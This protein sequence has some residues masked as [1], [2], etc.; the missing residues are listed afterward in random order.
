MPSIQQMVP[1]PRSVNSTKNFLAICLE[2]PSLGLIDSSDRNL[3]GCRPHRTALIT[4][5]LM[6]ITISTDHTVFLAHRCQVRFSF[7]EVTP[8]SDDNA[9]CV[10]EEKCPWPTVKARPCS[11]GKTSKGGI[12]VLPV[13]L[14]VPRYQL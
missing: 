8:V 6:V 4:T 10:V 13:W 11:L 12:A 7:T 5:T 2:S 9:V 1:N 14:T 3:T